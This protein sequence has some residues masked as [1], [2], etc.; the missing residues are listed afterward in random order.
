[1]ALPNL[2]DPR[3]LA[4][5][6]MQLEGQVSSESLTRLASAVS[7]IEGPLEACIQFEVD[8][9][10]AKYAHG[11]LSIIVETTCQRCLDKLR[12]PLQATFAAEIIWSEDQAD[13]VAADRDPWLVGDKMASLIELLEDEILLALPLVNY[14][15]VGKCTGDTFYSKEEFEEEALVS[16]NPFAVLQ[17]LKS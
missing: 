5:Q 1:M 13:N 10:G 8:E 6:G 15:D 4:L 7:S 16:D 9:A 3:K 2:I 17:Q 14:H 11:N 12:L